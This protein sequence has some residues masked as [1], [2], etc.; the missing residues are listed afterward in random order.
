MSPDIQAPDKNPGQNGAWPYVDSVS[1]ALII[2]LAA[3][4]QVCN[5]DRNS[6]VEGSR[7][8]DGRFVRRINW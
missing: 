6:G 5:A 1:N 2:V 7:E 4:M 3:T 8:R